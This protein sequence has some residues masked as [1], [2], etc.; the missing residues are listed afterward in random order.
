MHA[1][2]IRLLTDHTAPPFSR[3]N[4]RPSIT[5]VQNV[6]LVPKCK[7]LR[8]SYGFFQDTVVHARRPVVSPLALPSLHLF[9]KHLPSK[10]VSPKCFPFS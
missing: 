5:K 3:L 9:L 6:L 10:V 7:Y 4:K 1:W 2:T 8:K